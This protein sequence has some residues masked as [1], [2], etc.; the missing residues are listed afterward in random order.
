MPVVLGVPHSL[1]PEEPNRGR[2][3]YLLQVKL[4]LLL[5]KLLIL[6]R[7]YY[8]HLNSFSRKQCILTFGNLIELG[9][10][11]SSMVSTMGSDCRIL[12]S[13][14]L[15]F[16]PINTFWCSLYVTSCLPWCIKKFLSK[17]NSTVKAESH[18]K[19]TL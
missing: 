15:C 19:D 13:S 6:S 10:K 3:V 2:T 7:V 4:K 17:C 11:C 12:I 14:K 16:Q 9:L 1:A 18:L 5:L 8:W